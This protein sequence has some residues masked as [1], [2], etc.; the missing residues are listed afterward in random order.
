MNKDFLKALFSMIIFFTLVYFY[1]NINIE[2]AKLNK[3]FSK[4]VRSSIE[5]EDD[6]KLLEVRYNNLI[7][8]QRLEEK[9]LKVN[10]NMPDGEKII[11]IKE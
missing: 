7:R 11:R 1:M 2:N 9:A 3:K 10:M 5:L 4:L 6:I 8:N